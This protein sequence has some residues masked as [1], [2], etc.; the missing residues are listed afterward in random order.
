MCVLK[1]NVVALFGRVATQ[2]PCLVYP[3]L[4]MLINLSTGLTQK[5]IQA[6]T[7]DL[8]TRPLF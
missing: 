1:K 5:E 7:L 4:Y 3:F 6:P 2:L 8:H